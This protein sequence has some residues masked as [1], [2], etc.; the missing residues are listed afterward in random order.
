MPNKIIGKYPNIF[1]CKK[2]L[3]TVNCFDIH[4]LQLNNSQKF[5]YLIYSSFCFCLQAS[6]KLEHPI[7]SI[8]K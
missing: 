5:I 3:A 7:H 1:G 4:Q 2:D 6:I 8:K